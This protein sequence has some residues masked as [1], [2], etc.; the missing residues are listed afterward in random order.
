MTSVQIRVPGPGSNEE[1]ETLTL[2]KSLWGGCEKRNL[3][4]KGD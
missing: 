2:L 3:V 1:E 4:V